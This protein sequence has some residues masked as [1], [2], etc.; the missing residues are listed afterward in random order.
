MER[1]SVHDIAG[2]LIEERRCTVLGEFRV[3]NVRRQINRLL[4]VHAAILLLLLQPA[5]VSAQLASGV[6]DLCAG[7][8]STIAAGQ[9]VT[10]SA[11]ATYDC[12]GIHGTVTLRAALRAT[13]ILVYP[14]GALELEPGASITIRDVRPTDVEQFGTGLLVFGRLLARGAEKTPYLRMAVEPRAAATTLTLERAPSGWAIGDELFLPDTRQTY[15]DNWF[16]RAYQLQ[17]EY[18]TIAA[19]AGATIT[20]SAPLT[21]DHRGARDAD[22]TPTVLSD[23]TK[24]LPHVANLSRSI[25]VRS[26]NPNG[27]RGHVLMTSRADVDIRGVVFRD[28]GRTKAEPLDSAPAGGGTNQI[29]RYPVH[30]H[31]LAGP[32][33]PTNTGYQ[34]QIV[35]N[36][37]RDSRKWPI[38]IHGSHYGLVE[39]NVV[40]GGAQLTGSGIALE[41]G[42]ETENLIR[43]NFVGDIRGDINP[44]NSG[45]S[46]DNGTTP[47][48]GAECIW[49]AGFNNRFVENVVTGCRNPNQQIVSGVGFKFI[50]IPAPS[51]NTRRNPLF[52]GADLVDPN[53]TVGVNSQRQA[54][55]QFDGNE[56]YGV[57]A[58]GFTAWQLGTDGYQIHAN[59]P[60]T[61]LRNFR[62]W[63]TYEAAI[64]NYPTNHLTIDG[65]V[66]RIDASHQRYPAAISS[67]DYRSVDWTI[68]G[69]D[70]HAGAVWSGSIDPVG[71]M[72]VEGIRATTWEHAIQLTT[73]ATP[74]TQAGHAGLAVTVVV[75]DPVVTAWPGQPRRLLSLEHRTDRAPYDTATPYTVTLVEGASSSR[76]W[77]T[78]Q[79]TQSIYGGQAPANATT[80]PD[81]D[82]L[83][84]GGTTPPPAPVD[85]VVSPWSA[86]SPAGDWSAC[87]AG[88]Q[89]RTETRTRAVVT[90]ASNGGSTPTLTETHTV[91]QACAVEPAP[92]ACEAGPQGPPGPAGPAGPVGPQGPPGER[93]ESVTGPA[94]PVG[95]QGPAGPTLPGTVLLLPSSS[96][97]PSG[98]VEVSAPLRDVIRVFGLRLYVKS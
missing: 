47:G 7:S 51:A 45:P 4:L 88:T 1:Q 13:T 26:E 28:L 68:R 90:P 5:R 49:G 53:E 63:H 91:T 12:L 97:A 25:T 59:Q 82:G 95:P 55:L 15:V 50:S 22:G 80:R 73:P 39:G 21:H 35:G 40:I 2:R 31:M 93:G 58:D 10:I 75:R 38:A 30:V 96:A 32:R 65:L 92:C 20:L 46:T 74:G 8:P 52:R 43:R 24:L 16:N 69:G 89:S 70:V 33:N 19:I 36:V 9:A 23:G 76:V 34:F 42:S 37:V 98:Y 87:T 85:A 57:M 61:V 56:A 86:W 94:G 60:E 54:I 3:Q 44:R 29:G 48:S 84:S 67:G 66:Y 6:P 41:D 83:V 18:R 72:R 71:T 77:W 62:V 27:T 81:I 79:R 64:W 17:H 14:D 11:A 78:V